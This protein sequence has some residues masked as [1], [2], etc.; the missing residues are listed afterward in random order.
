MRFLFTS[1]PGTGHIHPLVPVAMALQANGH[2]VVFASSRSVS[3]SLQ[4]IG[5]R[6]L[7]IGP[8]WM[9]GGDDPIASRL[10]ALDN[11]GQ[12]KLF[13]ELAA[14]GAVSALLDHCE[15]W[16]P[17]AIVCEHTEY[18]GRLVGELAGIPVATKLIGNPPPLPAIRVLVADLLDSVRKDVGLG[19]DPHLER[20]YGQLLLDS[21]PPS[22]ALTEA[23]PLHI[24]RKV[25]PHVFDAG[26]DES[27]PDWVHG[28]SAQPVVYASLGTVFN[29]TSQLLEKIVEALAGEAVTLIVTTGRNRDPQDLGRLPANVRAERYIPQTLLFPRCSIVISHGGF[30]TMIAALD[31]GLPMYLLPLSADQP[32]NTVRAV[33]A[34]FA[35]SAADT[36]E[37]PFGPVVVPANLDPLRVRAGV[38]RLLAEAGF[39]TAAVR[40][41][42]EIDSM[43]GLGYEGRLLEQLASTGRGD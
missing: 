10:R 23:V 21:V 3:D 5:F 15:V 13:I 2:E 42:A 17:D 1:L 35:L 34:G 31:N 30:N 39:A 26:G 36:G 19:S 7:A 4:R 11:S 22:L 6:H 24:R 9:E 40:A 16:R 43:P 20:F 38:Q 18:A 12:N 28:L 8:D 32:R 29:R 14:M 25:R 37:P 27:L 41:K 33:E